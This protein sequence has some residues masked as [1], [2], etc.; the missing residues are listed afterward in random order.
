M[1]AFA[2]LTL[3]ALVPVLGGCAALAVGAA[4]GVAAGAIIEHEHNHPATGVYAR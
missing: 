3:L 1:K 4:G 2:I